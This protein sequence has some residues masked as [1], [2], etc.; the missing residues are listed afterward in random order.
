[1]KNILNQIR[2]AYC[3]EGGSKVIEIHRENDLI[4]LAVE[5]SSTVEHSGDVDGM[6]SQVYDLH[7]VS[8]TEDGVT[9]T[10]KSATIKTQ[11]GNRSEDSDYEVYVNGT[12]IVA[13]SKA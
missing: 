4:T 9:Y 7:G 12:V 6:C 11:N 3:W 8:V 1:M 10:V 2:D 5:G 13:C